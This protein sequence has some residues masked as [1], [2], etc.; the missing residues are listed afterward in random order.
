M[1]EAIDNL[2]KKIVGLIKEAKKRK[3]KTKKTKNERYFEG[4]KEAFE[5]LLI[6]V[7][8]LRYEFESSTKSDEEERAADSDESTPVDDAEA[9]L[10]AALASDVITRKTS[11]YFHENFPN[12]KVQGKEKVLNLLKDEATATAVRQQF[13]ETGNEQAVE[14]NAGEEGSA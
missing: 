4:Q 7:K 14:K 10:D 1:I 13:D 5:Q 12:G 11:Y 3:K 8:N 6:E 9:L 2:E